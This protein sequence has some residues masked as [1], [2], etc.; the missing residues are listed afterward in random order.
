MNLQICPDGTLGA[1]MASAAVPFNYE[2]F[3]AQ[4]ARLADQQEH[5]REIREKKAKAAKATQRNQTRKL[6]KEYDQ[7]MD[8]WMK[9]KTFDV[10]CRMEEIEETLVKILG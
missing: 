6:N 2:A 9:E 10:F 1:R 8:S 5:Y 4:Q 3:N 7:L